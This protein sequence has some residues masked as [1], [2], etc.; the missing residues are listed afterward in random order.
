MTVLSVENLTISYRT[1]RQ[2]REVVHNVS[3]TLGGG[4]AG[5]CRRIR[6]RQNDHGAG[7]HWP[8]GG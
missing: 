8:A 1:A 3:F 7:D 4:N 2:W 6:F 5:V